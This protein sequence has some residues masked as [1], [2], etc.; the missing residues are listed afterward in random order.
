[1]FYAKDSKMTAFQ[2]PSDTITTAA[3]IHFLHYIKQLHLSGCTCM[4]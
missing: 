4:T 2:Q 3:N 1:M